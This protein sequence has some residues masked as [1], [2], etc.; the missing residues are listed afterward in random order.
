MEIFEVDEVARAAIRERRTDT[1]DYGRV[2]ADTLL[3]HGLA[4]VASGQTDMAN[5]ERA[6]SLT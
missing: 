5:V 3:G 6:V 1:L 2:P 4:L